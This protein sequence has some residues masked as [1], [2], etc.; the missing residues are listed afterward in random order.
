ME[1][2]DDAM[3]WEVLDHVHGLRSGDGGS[4][5]DEEDEG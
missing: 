1:W 5:D 2:F 4:E 3:V